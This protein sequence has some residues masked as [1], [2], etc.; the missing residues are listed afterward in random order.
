MN[1]RHANRALSA[2]ELEK[3]RRQAGVLF[4]H[5][6]TA[7]F[8]EKKFGI[9]STTAK[10][11]KTRWKEG[12]LGARPE[13]RHGKLSAKQ[14]KKVVKLILKGPAVSGYDTQLWTLSRMTELVRKECSVAY[15]P[16]SL[17]Y[18]LHTLGFSCQKPSRKA[19]ERDEKAIACWIK[20]KW[21]TLL[22]RGRALA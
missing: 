2:Q 17:W 9:S 12:T 16:R 4:T 15:R 10:E 21:P 7:Y 19:K 18:L 6:K 20:Q 3:R 11:W 8:V 13:G 1:Y 22:K 14:K 5:G